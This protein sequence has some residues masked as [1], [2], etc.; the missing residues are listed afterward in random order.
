VFGQHSNR[1]WSR[2]SE[3]S[4]FRS[5]K[6]AARARTKSS[7]V[8]TLKCRCV[9]ESYGGS[10]TEDCLLS[11]GKSTSRFIQSQIFNEDFWRLSEDAFERLAEVIRTHACASREDLHR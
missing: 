11:F 5:S 2:S 3:R 1:F 10:D 6:A 9:S 8:G 7:L 4:I